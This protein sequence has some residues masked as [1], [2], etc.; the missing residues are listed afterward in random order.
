MNTDS[1]RQSMMRCKSID[2]MQVDLVGEDGVTLHRH[3]G[4]WQLVLLGIGVIVGAGIFSVTGM[5]AGTYA[6]PGIVL[7]FVIAAIACALAGLCYSEFAS[8][9]P[10]A[11]SAYTYSYLTLGEFFAWIIGWDLVLEYA[12]GAATVASAWSAYLVK[13]LAEL[14]LHFP[15][16]WASSPFTKIALEDGTSLHGIVNLPAILIVFAMTLVLVKGIRES[17]L[18]NAFLVA[19]K[20]AVVLAFIALGWMYINAANHQPFI[21]ANE[22]AFGHFGWSGVLRGAAVVFFAYIGFDCISTAAQEA[23][24]PKRDMPFGILMSLLIC[25]VLYCLFAYVLTGLASYKEFAGHD[26]LAPVAIAIKHTPYRVFTLLVEIAILAGFSSVIMILLM[27]QSRIFYS[28]ARDGL[29]PSFFSEIHP[30]FRTPWK[31]NILFAV[32]VSLFAGFIPG[33]VVGE[34]C[35]IGTLLAFTMVCI[36]VIVLRKT[37][38]D[39][40]R[41]FRVPLV[42]FIPA[43]GALICLI[44]M[45]S[46]PWDT[47]LRLV[48]WL[49]IGLGVYFGY[50]RHRSKLTH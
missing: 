45:A 43:A 39:A 16:Q 20:L 10:A 37:K 12:V 14:G 32:F 36:A 47:W 30:T 5:A 26:G 38:P 11:G 2:V 25:T 28:M 33:N 13:F 49:L 4:P 44:L 9:V 42:P 40:P 27:G 41:Q 29:L 34:M 31:S 24:N 6:G 18:L 7:S 22:G 17:A 1:L 50:S 21:P 15:I 23:R 46:L 8:M 35:S 19:V 48:V 3:L